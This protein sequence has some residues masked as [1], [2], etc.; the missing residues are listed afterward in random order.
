VATAIDESENNDPHQLNLFDC[1]LCLV[2]DTTVDGGA[3][4][5]FRYATNARQVCGGQNALDYSVD[6]Y[7]N[8]GQ[9]YWWDGSTRMIAY[10]VWWWF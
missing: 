6:A 4:L 1:I 10:N 2:D 5:T 9:F 8:L 3:P 7:G